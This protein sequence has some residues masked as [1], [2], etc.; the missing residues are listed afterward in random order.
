VK[1]EVTKRVF[2]FHLASRIIFFLSIL[3]LL[4]ACET[5][6]N[7]FITPYNTNVAASQIAVVPQ[8]E[9]T[10]SMLSADDLNNDGQIGAGDALIFAAT[11]HNVGAVGVNLV[12][13][14]LQPVS[15][16]AGC[17]GDKTL[18]VSTVI[19][20]TADYPITSAEV[21]AG[22]VTADFA[23]QWQV[24]SDT[25]P[26]TTLG[27]AVTVPLSA[28]TVEQPQSTVGPTSK[29][30]AKPTPVATVKPG[31]VPTIATLTSAYFGTGVII[32]YYD[33]SGRTAAEIGASISQNFPNKTGLIEGEASTQYAIDYR[34]A[35][36]TT[37]ANCQIADEAQPPILMT[38]TVTL[39]HWV[40]PAGV[41]AATIK[42]VADDFTRVIVHERVHVQYDLAADTAANQALAASNCNNMEANLNQVWYQLEVK[43]CQFDLD[44][45]AAAE[46]H[47]MKQCLAGQF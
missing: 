26:Q 25:A 47:T 6:A 10:T 3:F 33:I 30:V 28:I 2:R 8:I 24:T 9:V 21:V 38:V 11:V 12:S 7:P 14:Q 46:G 42:L 23:V 19:M 15:V 1:K 39:P 22:Q 36:E 31:D 29:P 44:E 5:A 27:T 41:D 13:A 32:N 16:K 43:N 45:Y 34:F 18:K 20:C 17:L 37:G 35:T 4:A 40:Q